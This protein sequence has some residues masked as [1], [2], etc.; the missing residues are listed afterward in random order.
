MAET[1]A[2]LGEFALIRDLLQPV[3][4]PAAAGV[5]VGIGDDGAVLTVPR[6]QQLVATVDGLVEGIHFAAGA[7][8]D[9]LAR[10][11][12]RVNLSDLAAMGARPCW[13][14]LSLSLPPETP[15]TWVERFAAGLRE[16]G[17]RFGVTVVGGNTTGSLGGIFVNVTLMGLVSQDRAMLRSGAQAG[18]RI[19][20]SGTIGDAALGLAVRQGRL[21]VAADRQ[22]LEERLDLPEP[23]VALGLAL[24][25]S[26]VAHG[27][28]DLSDGL[29]ADLGHLCAASGVGAVIETGR[30]PFSPVARDLLEKDGALL[31]LLL[32]GGEDYE[33]LFTVSPGAVDLVAALARE[34]GVPLTDIGEI[35]TGETIQ[36]MQ[37]GQ[38][39]ALDRGG[40]R[41]F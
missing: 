20:V 31:P 1:V 5:A 13:Y 9:R 21:A 7:D 32:T 8:P 36:V 17:E 26:A 11:A 41:H 22:F 23:R 18:D 29:V 19:V 14:L 3:Q 28:I 27:V 15:L 39:L 24:A 6:T 37:G 16:E 40:W 2:G 35:T 30:I 4:L 38:P 25:D 12:L 10:K 34:V 33:L